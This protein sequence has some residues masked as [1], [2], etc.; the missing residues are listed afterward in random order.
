MSMANLSTDNNQVT[1][2]ERLID[3]VARLHY[4][5]HHLRTMLADL[6][7]EVAETRKDIREMKRQH[8]PYGAGADD[9]EAGFR[10]VKRRREQ[11]VDPEMPALTATQT[12][13]SAWS[14]TERLDEY[15]QGDQG[16]AEK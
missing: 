15:A 14:D 2:I 7:V 8:D 10:A 3:L 16:T 6:Q 5:L 12:L 9:A 1:G 4:R 11:A 13:G